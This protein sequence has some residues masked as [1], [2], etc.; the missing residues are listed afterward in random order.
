MYMHLSFVCL[1]VSIGGPSS[2]ICIAY[3]IPV[4]AE[5]TGKCDKELREFYGNSMI[6]L[7]F[8]CKVSARRRS[9]HS[10]F[11]CKVNS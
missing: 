4:V 5:G 10:R 3:Y 11:F 7:R 6:K 9:I 1:I 2:K 8:F